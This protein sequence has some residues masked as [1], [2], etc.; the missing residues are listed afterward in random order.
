KSHTVVNHFFYYRHVTI[1]SEALEAARLHQKIHNNTRVLSFGLE[2]H[3]QHTNP[4]TPMIKLQR[5]QK[6]SSGA[7]NMCK[8]WIVLAAPHITNFTCI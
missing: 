1:I 4:M 3:Q 6:I 5:D 2:A 7:R 8:E